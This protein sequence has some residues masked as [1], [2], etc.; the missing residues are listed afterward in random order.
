MKK[1]IFYKPLPLPQLYTTYDMYQVN[2]DGSCGFRAFLP[3]LLNE[4]LVDK[5][6]KS[7]L[8]NLRTTI[9]ELAKQIVE[10]VDLTNTKYM[11]IRPTDDPDKLIQD[12]KDLLQKLDVEPTARKLEETEI[13]LLVKFMRQIMLMNFVIHSYNEIVKGNSNSFNISKFEEQFSKSLTGINRTNNFIKEFWV[14]GIDFIIFGIP[15]FLLIDPDIDSDNDKK[16]FSCL[17]FLPPD[18]TFPDFDRSD[19]SFEARLSTSKFPDFITPSIIMYQ[20]GQ[21][22]I[23]F[24]YLVP[25]D[26]K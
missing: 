19:L 4:I 20:H 3:I 21:N 11:E 16:I 5:K 2:H 22:G 15:Y 6:W 23:M 18:N 17:Y 14:E 12:T 24:E 8:E 13:Q 9:Y 1:K 7:W 25:K 26:K 10:T